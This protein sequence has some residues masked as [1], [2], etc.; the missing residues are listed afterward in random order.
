VPDQQLGL[1]AV[2][3]SPS[4]RHSHY[5]IRDFLQIM[6]TPEATKVT[7][8]IINCFPER[9]LFG[10]DSVAPRAQEDYLKTYNLYAALLAQL[11]PKAR[12]RS[13]RGFTSASSTKHGSMSESGKQPTNRGD[14]DRDKRGHEAA[15]GFRKPNS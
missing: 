12:R 1:A 3:R 13:S 6:G 5:G 2:F 8:N 7:A 11:T 10:T 4:E 15:R 14:R 9:F